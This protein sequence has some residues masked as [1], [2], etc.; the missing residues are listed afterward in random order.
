M[1]TMNAEPTQRLSALEVLFR[2]HRERLWQSVQQPYQLSVLVSTHN[3]SHYSLLGTGLSDHSRMGKCNA[4]IVIQTHHAASTDVR[5]LP[6]TT[7]CYQV[8]LSSGQILFEITAKPGP[9]PELPLDMRGWEGRHPSYLTYTT[10]GPQLQEYLGIVMNQVVHIEPER[11][12]IEESPVVK[13]GR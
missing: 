7:I 11:A 10:R 4:E 12:L 1:T 6:N 3:R 9:T 5:Y 8:D 13:L 2:P